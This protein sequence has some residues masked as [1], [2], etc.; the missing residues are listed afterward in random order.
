M[1]VVVGADNCG[2][3][4]LRLMMWQGLDVAGCATWLHRLSS[5]ASAAFGAGGFPLKAV[6]KW[7]ML[8]CTQQVLK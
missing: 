4:W 2:V 5:L 7:K 1:P 8:E 6:G 3:I